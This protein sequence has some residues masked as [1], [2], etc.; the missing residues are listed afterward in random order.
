MTTKIQY[1]RNKELETICWNLSNK[2]IQEHRNHPSCGTWRNK[3]SPVCPSLNQLC[4]TTTIFNLVKAVH[5]EPIDGFDGTSLC[6]QEV[7][8]SLTACSVTPRNWTN[9]NQDSQ[10]EMKPASW[11]SKLLAGAKIYWMLHPENAPLPD[12]RCGNLTVAETQLKSGRFS[13]GSQ[14]TFP[15]V[16]EKSLNWKKTNSRIIQ[17]AGGMNIKWDHSQKAGRTVRMVRMV[18]ICQ[19]SRY[20]EGG[21]DGEDGE[22]VQ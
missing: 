11:L 19:D 6:L 17:A 16:L 3:E 15:K 20:G 14:S 2:T 12:T 7:L 8:Q 21:E 5:N 1:Q 18:R 9:T 22:D 10:K 13:P 4:L